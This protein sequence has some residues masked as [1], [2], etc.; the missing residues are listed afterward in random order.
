VSVDDLVK[1]D[2]A[3]ARA[4]IQTMKDARKEADD[5]AAKLRDQMKSDVAAQAQ[6]IRT[7][8]QG[9][10]P[11]Q[12]QSPLA[13]VGDFFEKNA[14]ELTARITELSK[15]PGENAALLVILKDQRDKA[16]AV[17]AEND[18]FAAKLATASR[19][20]NEGESV[21]LALDALGKAFNAQAAA[22]EESSLKWQ[23]F[24]DS[25]G[26]Q[27][28]S[29]R[30]TKVNPA[31]SYV[32]DWGGGVYTCNPPRV[33]HLTGV[34]KSPTDHIVRLN[35]A[36]RGSVVHAILHVDPPT[37]GKGIPVSAEFDIGA[38]ETQD[39]D[40]APGWEGNTFADYHFVFNSN[41]WWVAVELTSPRQLTVDFSTSSNILNVSCEVSLDKAR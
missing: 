23:T 24:L 16:L 36:E 33:Q 11:S 32:G 30:G 26:T 38:A 13:Q 21:A 10:D 40:K 25:I 14:Q 6:K 35:L 27:L 28:D 31:L 34:S 3:K 5:A 15:K 19:G 39:A 9:T 20:R 29:L 17:K 22:D 1:M 2:P 41:K 8:P 12:L 7:G 37:T 18:A 4:A